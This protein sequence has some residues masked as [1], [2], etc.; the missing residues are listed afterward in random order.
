MGVLL[1][2]QFNNKVETT[3]T[4]GWRGL[5]QLGLIALSYQGALGCRLPLKEWWMFVSRD[6]D[7]EIALEWIDMVHTVLTHMGRPL[8]LWVCVATEAMQSMGKL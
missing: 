8:D 2:R 6:T 1:P 5:K 7:P 4:R 3:T